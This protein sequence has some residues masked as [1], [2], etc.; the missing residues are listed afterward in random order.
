MKRGIYLNENLH[1]HSQNVTK[2]DRQFLHGHQSYVLWFTGLSGSGKSTIANALESKLYQLGLS[3]YL[4]DGDN[5]R[6]GLNSDLT[7]AKKDRKENIRRVGEVCKLFV[8]SGIIVLSAFIS[9]YRD[10]RNE[11]R[12]LLNKKEF[13]EIY[14]KCPLEICEQRDPKG[15]YKLAREGKIKDFTGI[16][17][18]Y[19]IPL[20]PELI[21]DTEKNSI[22]KNVDEIIQYLLKEQLL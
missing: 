4:L 20:Q 5:V 18:A 12:S 2:R 10:D 11:V 13:I 14:V 7:F 17:S 19:E 8:D 1:W 3:T 21:L 15:L 6:H 9:P 16:S 22:S